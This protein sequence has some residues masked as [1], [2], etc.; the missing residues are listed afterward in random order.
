MQK[1]SYKNT[2]YFI[3]IVI[4]A[5]LGI[6]LYWNFKNYETGKQQLIN[7]VQ[8]SLDNAVN[9]YYE[10][11]AKKH[12]VGFSSKFRDLSDFTLDTSIDS[13][14]K[15]INNAKGEYKGLDF[16]GTTNLEG[17]SI[18]N[19]KNIDSIDQYLRTSDS[20]KSNINFIHLDSN[21]IETPKNSIQK[22]AS[23]IIFSIQKNDIDIKQ[24]D[25]L[26][27]VELQRKQ[28]DINYGIQFK[29]YS[30]LHSAVYK[31][32]ED[33][34]KIIKKNP[35]KTQS[36]SSYLPLGS[37][38]ELFFTN[39]TL[40]IFKKN[41]FGMLLSFILVGAV[42]GCLLYLLKIIN[43]QKQLAELKN[44][45]ISNITHEFK[46][47]IATISAAIEGIQ[48]F[49]ENND[50]EKTKK[51]A[52][53]SSTQLDKLNTMVEKI[54]ETATLDSDEL[55]LNLEEINLVELIDNISEKHKANTPE[56]KIIFTSS[57][58]NIWKGV[59]VF[60]LENAINN[61]VDNAVK[62]GGDI[63][64]IHISHAVSNTVITI[65]DTG[66][67]LTKAHKEKIFEKFYRVPKGNTH[68]VKGFGIG[69]FYTKTIIEKHGGAI[70]LLLDQTQTNFK[71]TLP[72]G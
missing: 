43:H 30:K 49:N 18:L 59:D 11:L 42:I 54:L 34:A 60:H 33:Y 9:K 69:L 51:Y 31:S 26:L 68:D 56:K 8:I 50:P 6:Q 16:W 20:I 32:N 57:H 29:E 19:G 1:N 65:K 4:V 41:L 47:P 72:N 46:T 66:T 37:T 48:N 13:I 17:I 7:E 25:S 45:L 28:L 39:S 64:S 55:Q 67:S 71:I 38:L 40:V 63:I 52:A 10:E 22:L 70:Q 14:I 36:K 58:K 23:K 35:L 27:L 53:M 5:T 21:H 3:T 15:N 2:L 12:T 61:I 62:Y 44:D 24:I